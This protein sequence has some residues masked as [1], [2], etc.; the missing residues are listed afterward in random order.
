MLTAASSSSS[1]TGTPLVANFSKWES[2][3]AQE[4]ENE[5]KLQQN[6]A[7]LCLGWLI[8]L[9][10]RYSPNK[11]SGAM[12]RNGVAVA[13]CIAVI[14]LKLVLDDIIILIYEESDVSQTMPP[15]AHLQY[16]RDLLLFVREE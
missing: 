11:R 15:V 1:L 5:H 4:K 7:L 8:Q 13:L 14:H 9:G 3:F 12:T 10:I 6:C 16:T 2:L